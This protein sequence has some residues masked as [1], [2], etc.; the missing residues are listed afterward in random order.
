MS[1]KAGL[2]WGVC[3]IKGCPAL[4]YCHCPTPPPAAVPHRAGGWSFPSLAHHSHP[5]SHGRDPGGARSL[6]PSAVAPSCLW[7][8]APFRLKYLLHEGLV[9]QPPKHLIDDSELVTAS[10]TMAG[11]PRPALSVCCNSGPGWSQQ[12]LTHEARGWK[13][14]TTSH[15]Q[16]KA[17]SLES[18]S[19]KRQR[20]VLLH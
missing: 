1:Q 5:D 11:V 4:Q 7:E 16:G 20:P 15:C 18:L 2:D 19:C 13:L 3:L 9:L 14:P 10:I 12:V 17:L 6:P 8:H